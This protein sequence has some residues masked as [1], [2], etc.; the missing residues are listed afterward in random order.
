MTIYQLSS[1]SF[2]LYPL[3]LIYRYP[4]WWDKF[5]VLEF[6]V[7]FFFLFPCRNMIKLNQRPN[8][9]WLN[10]LNLKS[11]VHQIIFFFFVCLCIHEEWGYFMCFYCQKWIHLFSMSLQLINEKKIMSCYTLMSSGLSALVKKLFIRAN[12]RSSPTFYKCRWFVATWQI[13][14]EADKSINVPPTNFFPG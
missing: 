13:L 7:W 9:T 10:L 14:A 3:P 6:D 12:F 1:L 5:L 11:K 8:F 2:W 4:W